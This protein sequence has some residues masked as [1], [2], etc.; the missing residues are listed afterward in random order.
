VA[1][2]TNLGEARLG[3]GEAR[4][5]VAGCAVEK[6]G[7]NATRLFDLAPR[8]AGKVGRIQPIAGVQHGRV[9]RVAHE[10]RDRLGAFA[11]NEQDHHGF[12]SRTIR[13]PPVQTKSRHVRSRKSSPRRPRPRAGHP[14]DILHLLFHQRCDEVGARLIGAGPDPLAHDDR[15]GVGM[16]R[17][18]DHAIRG[19][20]I[21]EA[22]AQGG[23]Q[24]GI[25]RHQIDADQRHG[26]FARLQPHAARLQ[27]VVGP[28]CPLRARAVAGHV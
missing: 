4:A 12:I 17:G 9:A 1:K 14:D 27:R 18:Q 21:R 3:P 16:R 6:H 5:H 15:A 25:H 22:L 24:A 13:A 2:A 26:E 8:D 10:R 28:E 11:L 19:Q 7:R 20:D 23:H